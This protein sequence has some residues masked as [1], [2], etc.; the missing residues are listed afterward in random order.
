MIHSNAIMIFFGRV[1]L[2]LSLSVGGRDTR[3]VSKNSGT[4][5]VF[6]LSY[7]EF[8]FQILIDAWISRLYPI[9]V[10]YSWYYYS[11]IRIGIIYPE[12]GWSNWRHESR[13]FVSQWKRYGWGSCMLP[14]LLRVWRRHIIN[15]NYYYAVAL[16]DFLQNFL[17]T[18]ED[19]QA[20]TKYVAQLVR[21]MDL[22][23]I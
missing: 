6:W 12:S 16:E 15:D 4:M 14:L 1:S 9:Q 7:S 21:W 5:M 17:E 11:V 2:C 3:G 13:G 18:G 23:L 20:R 22:F 8:K 10:L 19:G